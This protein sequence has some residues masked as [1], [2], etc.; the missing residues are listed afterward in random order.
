MPSIK[1]LPKQLANQIAAGEVVERPASVVKE[2]LENAVDAKG[3][4]ILCEIKNAGKQL[5]RIRDNGI[6]IVRD[7]LPLALA[8]HATSKISTVEDLN[9]IVTLGFRGEALAS[10]A[11]V[12]KLTLSSKTKEQEHG[13][14]VR[15]EGPEQNPV[16]EPFAHPEGTTVDVAE[17]FFNTPARRRFLKSDRTEFL[18]IKDIFTRVALAHPD[19]GFELISDSKSVVRVSPSKVENGIDLRRT[20]TLLGADFSSGGISVI[21]EDPAIQIEGMMLEPPKETDAVSEQIY[22]F[23]NGRPI[24]DKLVTHALKEAFF[25]VLGKTLPIRCVLYFSVD[26][27]E[28]DVNVHPRKDEVRFHNSSLIHDLIVDNIVLALRK[29]GIGPDNQLNDVSAVS[30]V[31][32]FDIDSK[33]LPAFPKGVSSFNRSDSLVLKNSNFLNSDSVINNNTSDNVKNYSDYLDKVI[34]SSAFYQDSVKSSSLANKNFV[35][36]SFS[37]LKTEYADNLAVLDSVADDTLLVRYRGK[38]FLLNINNL[39][40]KKLSLEF[41]R[42]VISSELKTVKLTLPFTLVTDEIFVKALKTAENAVKKCGFV[43]KLYKTKVEI[44]QIPEMMKGCQ[45]AEYAAKALKLI[46][47]SF[48]SI[49]DDQIPVQLSD[50]MALTDSSLID[51]NSVLESVDSF[52]TSSKDPEVMAELNFEKIIRIQRYG[53]EK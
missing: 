38:F 23:L 50:L 5:I 32:S 1:V 19:I 17:L 30:H 53:N 11:S 18:R 3:T 2:L 10:I 16:V 27:S 28:V 39:K 33:D 22:L 13:Y 4:H 14:C 44:I 40:R 34:Q 29:Y 42:S 6:G 36:E 31:S 20:A 9:A 35:S 24:A 43:L 49:E 45:L 41:S 47:A 26:P 21:C 48:K 46:C 15:V 7:E 25:E 37:Q 52:E 12:S 51:V 8:P